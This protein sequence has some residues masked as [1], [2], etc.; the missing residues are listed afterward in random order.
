MFG[1]WVK[2]IAAYLIFMSLILK[3]MP[4]GKNTKYIKYFMGMVLILI[5][6]APAGKVFHINEA[7]D[8][9]EE[10]LERQE[11]SAAFSEE[12]ELAG[13]EYKENVIRQYEEEAAL[14]A[15]SVLEEKGYEYS[16]VGI[17]LETDV[18]SPSFGQIVSVEVDLSEGKGGVKETEENP[19]VIEK[20]KVQITDEDEGGSGNY[21]KTAEEKAVKELLAEKLC[22]SEEIIFVRYVS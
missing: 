10:E 9:F 14:W 8:Q 19:I 15:A 2:N 6:L 4:E 13:E 11:K 21:R 17:R 20:K 22:V 7:F 1:Q 3:L 5:V 18:E 16:A 12:L